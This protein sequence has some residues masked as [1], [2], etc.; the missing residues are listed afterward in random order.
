MVAILHDA[1]GVPNLI[2]GQSSRRGDRNKRLTILSEA[3]KLALYGLPNF[4]D[5]QRIEFLAMTDDE[6][7]LAFR[8]NGLLARI[9]CLLQI[10]YFKAKQ[11]FFRFSL[12]DVPPDDIAFLLQRYFPGQAPILQQ[13]LSAKEYYSQRK[14]I[15]AL[16]GYR[17]WLDEDLPRLLNKASL[18]AKI[19]VTPAFLLSEL[20]AFLNGQRIVRPGYT[21]L[22]TVISDA[23]SAERQRLEQRV[24]GA[25]D[26][27]ARTALQKLLVR[28]NTLS[29]LAA[30]QQDAKNFGHK[31]MVAERQ[32]R[33]TLAPFYAI[34]K[35][36]LPNLD[37]SILNI[38]YYAS[39]ADYYTI[40]D[41]RR[42]PS[43][44]CHLY[45][46]CYAWQRYRQL[47]DNLVDALGYH[48]QRLE[49]DTKETAN[50]QATQAQ[51]ERQQAVPRVG[52]LLL[53]YVDDR[54]EDTTPFGTVRRQA[55]SIMPKETLLSTGKL[56]SEKPINQMHLRWLAVDQQSGRC[57][58]NLRPLAMALDFDSSVVDSPWLAALLWMKSV[59]G[60]QQRLAE[61]PLN[62]IPKHTIPKR[63]RAS[64]LNF[65]Q[66]GNATSLRGERYEFW[67]YRQLRKRLDVGD[68]YLDDSV[69][70]RRF[71]DE[72]VAL[73]RKAEALK[74]LNIP[75]L[76]QPVDATLDGLFAKLDMLW[77][78]F[79]REL[80]QGK[81]KH[82]DFDSVNKTITWH[83]PK[84]ADDEAL[85]KDFY[86]KLV[87]SDITDIF[88]FVNEQC[89]FLSAMT[90]LQPR[91]AKKI[92]DEDSLMAV[93]LAQAMNHGNLNMAETSDI[94]YHVLEATHQQHLRQATLKKAN[95]QISNFIAQLPIFPFYSFDLDVLYGSVDGQKFSVADPT[96][97]ARHSR[98]YFGKDRGVVA[99]S[100]LANHVAL[101][102]ELLG[103]NQ[104]ESYW[105]FDICYNNTSDIVPATI[106]GDMHSINKAN[107]AI[108]HWFGMNLAPR[109]TN[110]QAQLKHLCC[111]CDP[112]EYANFLIP[113]AGQIDRK[114][115]TSEKANIDRIV[116]TL[117]LKEMSQST[118]VRKLCTLSGHHRTRKAIFEFDKLI[119]SIYTLRYLRD[120][121]LQRNV[122][123]S[124]NRIESYHQL[125]SALAQV[126]GRKELIGRTDL[127]VA[128]SNECG[129]LVAN[130]VIAYNSILLSGLLDRYQVAA[131]QKALELLK[132]ISPVAWQHIRFLGHYAFRDKQHPIDLEAILAWVNLQ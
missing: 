53:L 20:M 132:R 67:V 44:L 74:G 82:L 7:S 31:M 73:D 120:P 30:I 47:S 102:T 107:F 124:Q 24:E 80:R 18:L 50:Q 34:A 81:L 19:D 71:A 58:K 43:G 112:E 92:A 119:R 12:S 86:A 23:L 32:K 11:A 1:I 125:R 17:L 36:L 65:D 45:L 16:F 111:G 21:T 48:M 95:D 98:K 40:Y 38:A 93:I 72:L 2:S 117:G 62:E 105:V 8:R 85:Q 78:S 41:L 91:Y 79:D 75:W 77:R 104:H 13:P 76:A 25:L 110:L 5:F 4:D 96:V 127:D 42:L 63:L 29:E 88:R 70:H 106:T 64:L 49:D 39:L 99:Y 129:R 28:E 54:L 22:Q 114:L 100:L 113:P 101:Q 55:F 108:L 57:T 97:K 116:A 61:R 115:M 52:R 10:G 15:T 126:S 66:D 60:R 68:I 6:R 118:L 84:A 56:L 123:R 9:Y 94:P 103:A 121:Q 90:P 33:A 3:E 128:I 14:E 37:I 89:R 87:A 131:N 26:D 59:F 83:R 35:A 130:I 27:A 122:H 51:A 69:Q 46:L 109:F